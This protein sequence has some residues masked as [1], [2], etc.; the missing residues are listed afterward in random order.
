MTPAGTTQLKAQDL[1][2]PV[3]RVKKKKKKTC[4]NLPP[5][6]ASTTSALIRIELDERP[7]RRTFGERLSSRIVSRSNAS[8]SS[9]LW[10]RAVLS[11]SDRAPSKPAVCGISP[12]L[13]RIV[14]TKGDFKRLE[15][16]C[17]AVN[18]L[19]ATLGS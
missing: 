18:S 17:P 1:L 8:N 3:T 5:W 2:G 13:N 15:S 10:L 4:G 9:R 12:F 14:A 16:D 6:D 11:C 7:T 19:V